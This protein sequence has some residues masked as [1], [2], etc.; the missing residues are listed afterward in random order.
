M[1]AYIEFS[2]LIANK[3]FAKQKGPYNG[4]KGDG[5]FS[6][7]ESILSIFAIGDIISYYINIIP[8]FILFIH[9]YEYFSKKLLFFLF[10]KYNT[11]CFK[12]FLWLIFLFLKS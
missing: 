11:V 2:I 8:L 7:N 1:M 12:I 6:K 10:L 4:P 3:I 5:G 9:P